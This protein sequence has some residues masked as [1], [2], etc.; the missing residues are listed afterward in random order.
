MSSSLAFTWAQERRYSVP[1]IELALAHQ[2][3]NKILRAYLA[4]ML[5]ERRAMI[6]DWATFACAPATT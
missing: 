6:D 5:A 1:V 3:R 2:A 4:D